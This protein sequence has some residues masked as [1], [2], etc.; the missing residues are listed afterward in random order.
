[1]LLDDPPGNR[2]PETGT[3]IPGRVIELKDP[4][5]LVSVDSRSGIGHR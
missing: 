3:A 1:M 2:Q 4:L 5:Q